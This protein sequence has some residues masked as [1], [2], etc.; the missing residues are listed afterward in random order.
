VVL[1]LEV[2]TVDVDANWRNVLVM[3]VRLHDVEIQAVAEAETIVGVE[4]QLCGLRGL[5]PPYRALERTRSLPPA[6][7]PPASAQ[8]AAQAALTA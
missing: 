2:R 6:P 1:R 3:L 7:T 4:L 5:R 8:G